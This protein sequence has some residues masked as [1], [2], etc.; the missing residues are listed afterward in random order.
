MELKTLT[1]RAENFL[2][3]GQ[4]SEAA[5]I[6]SR[7]AELMPR[8][9][10]IH[11]VHGLVLMQQKLWEKALQQFD[12]AIALNPHSA[13]YHRSRGNA[14]QHAGDPQGAAEAFKQAIFLDP[15]DSSAMIDLGNA[16]YA[17]GG[18]AQALQWYQNAAELDPGDPMALNNI[19][20]LL[21][22]QGQMNQALQY[23]DKS[24]AIEPEYAEARFNRSVLLLARGEYADGWGEYEWRFRRKS[25]H[26]VYPRNYQV[27]PWNG[28]SY[29][30]KRLLV[31]CEQ[32]MGDMIQFC[33]Y[34]P[35]VKALGGALIVEAHAPLLSL[36]S[37]MTAADQVVPFNVHR[38][39]AVHFDLFAPLLSLPRLFRTT[40]NNIP[41]QV[42][43]LHADPHR[44]AKWSDISRHAK[45]LRI[46]LVWY[47]S[48][49]DLSRA[50]PIEQIEALFSVTD[51]HFFSL[52][53]GL[54]EQ[55]VARI[56]KFANV[57]HWGDRL[58][59]FGD[60]AAAIE[61]LDLIISVDTATAHLA[62]AL[63]K[64]VWVLLPAVADWRWLLD[65][66]DSPWY[67]TARLFRQQAANDWPT[68]MDRVCTALKQLSATQ[69]TFERGR[70]Y[71]TENRLDEAIRAYSETIAL[72]PD[73]EP[74]H[75]NLALAHFQKGDPHKAAAGYHRCLELNPGSVEVLTNLGAAY[76][77]MRQPAQAEAC[78]AKA[79]EIDPQYVPA[80][81]NQGNILLDR[82][83][84]ESAAAQY[85][86]ALTFD[87]G[88]ISSLCNLGRALHRSGLFDAAMDCY[89]KA[90]KIDPNHPETRLNRSVAFLLQGRWEEGWPEYEW[91]FQCHNRSRIYPHQPTG[92]RWQG[93]PFPGKTLLV[94]GEQGLGDSLQFV[95]FLPWVKRLGGCL[96]FETHKSLHPLLQGTAGI[97]ALLELSSQKAPAQPYDLH[98]PLC[99]LPG[100]FNLTPNNLPHPGCYLSA[101]E[102]KVKQWRKKLPSDGFNVGIVWSGSDTYP[103]RS[104]RLR[105]LTPL[106]QIDGIHWIGLQKGPGADQMNDSHLP[107]DWNLTNWGKE[108]E[109]FSD[110]AAAIAG[111]DL[112]I[113]IDTSVAHLAGALGK[114][115]W[116]LLPYVPDWRWLLLRFDTP[117]YP[118]MR[119]FRQK[120]PGN[121]CT[122]VMEI[123]EKL[124]KEKG[125]LTHPSGSPKHKMI[126]KKS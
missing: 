66:E 35:Q 112:V 106:G 25:A 10:D 62:G 78:Y 3:C 125:F 90:L 70:L 120:E 88:H 113:S 92:P 45:G 6:Y 23:Y 115:T 80:I 40:L 83:D 51:A 98:I 22:D 28:S 107:A 21:H 42:P 114:P 84:L 11:H 61:G 64:P 122:V 55:S 89:D 26:Q 99:S 119:L 30:G 108:L 105:D 103:E 75:R 52:Q 123:C 36:L 37:G 60:T 19:G 124:G 8:Q 7:L 13:V 85:R 100:L 109:D 87:P 29:A 76:Q 32:G 126:E 49:V 17:Q 53:K 95:R 27:D 117:W 56:S 14:L 104:C 31:H 41:N 77:H 81:Y 102:N 86:R 71:H 9:P 43:Y 38:Q 16:L 110:T 91:R 72:T 1:Q 101:P 47:G 34:L 116:L 74:A 12:R 57:T 93:E 15:R 69:S 97:D 18:S 44:A 121:W 94:H 63:G 73:I 59:D 48:T 54:A 20:K 5:A 79:L 24:L 4:W 67:P 2:A 46:G 68:L 96:L 65:R 33:R 118:T 111:L 58:N 82:G 39:P 50:C